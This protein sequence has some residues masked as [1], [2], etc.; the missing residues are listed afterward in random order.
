M[1]GQMNGQNLNEIRRMAE[2]VTSQA[3]CYLYDVEFVGGPQGRVLRVTIDKDI[4]GG[5]TIEDCTNVSRGLNQLL[6]GPEDV[7][8]E[9]KPEVIPGGNYFLEVSSPGLERPLRVPQHYERAIGKKVLI[10]SFQPLA[11][12][13]ENLTKELG[14]TKQVQG[15]LRSVDATGARVELLVPEKDAEPRALEVFVPM[16][17]VTKAHIV[18]EFV[19]V[20]EKKSPKKAKSKK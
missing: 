7:P 17:S 20:A 8:E 10:K 13:N 18:F 16:E 11:Q 5:V 15:A 19:D 1:I 12:F 2:E 6:D 4:E 14:I 9:E 3:G